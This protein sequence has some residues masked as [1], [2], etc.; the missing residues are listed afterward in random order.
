MRLAERSSWL[1]VSNREV[2]NLEKTA[3]RSWQARV[4]SVLT[5]KLF[6]LA[7][8]T[9]LLRHCCT[10]GYR[11]GDMLLGRRRN[12]YQKASWKRSDFGRDPIY[13]WLALVCGESHCS[14]RGILRY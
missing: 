14:I 5:S 13:F 10:N 11:S 8:I 3:S 12:S 7:I 6:V 1:S 9:N 2:S 4:P